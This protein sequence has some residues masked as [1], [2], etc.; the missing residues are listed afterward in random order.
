MGR[1]RENSGE[2]KPGRGGGVGAGGR[3][4]WLQDVLRRPAGVHLEPEGTFQ[5]PSDWGNGKKSRPIL[6]WKIKAD[7]SGTYSLPMG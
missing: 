3:E 2:H 1:E 7:S 4:W 6:E 5:I